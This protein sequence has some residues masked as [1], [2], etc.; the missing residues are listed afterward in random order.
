MRSF[1]GD[2]EVY[3]KRVTEIID[4]L[5]LNILHLDNWGIPLK[6]QLKL[7]CISTPCKTHMLHH[8]VEDI[9]R[10]GTSVHYETEHSE[11]FNKFIREE[12][13]CTNRHNPS[14][15]VAVAFAKRFIIHH[16]FSGESHL[17]NYKDPVSN[18][19]EI[20]RVVRISSG[21]KRV[22]ED[23]PKYFAI[24]FDSRENADNNDYQEASNKFLRVDTYGRF[25]VKTFGELDLFFGVIT[26]AVNGT[27]NNEAKYT[28]QKYNIEKYDSSRSIELS[29]TVLKYDYLDMHTKLNRSGFQDC[30][31]LNVLKFGSLWSLMRLN[32]ADPPNVSQ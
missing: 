16:I 32:A 4:E 5:T 12:I 6:K 14:K 26:V 27:R 19:L 11:Q 21:I 29:G 20:R 7:L 23:F 18:S 15:D 30:R 22:K 31:L 25:M 8:I 13:L 24:L 28:I 1:T 10:F 17:A 2:K 9:R 3:L